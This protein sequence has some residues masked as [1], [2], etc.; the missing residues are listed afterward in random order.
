MTK[1]TMGWKNC[2]V[3]IC[4]GNNKM[5]TSVAS[6]GIMPSKAFLCSWRGSA[7]QQRGAIRIKSKHNVNRHEWI[8][9]PSEQTTLRHKARLAT[10]AANHTTFQR[11]F[12]RVIVGCALLPTRQVGGGSDARARKHSLPLL[13]LLSRSWQITSTA[14]L[15]GGNNN[16][17]A[18]I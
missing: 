4:K 6:L 17:T 8:K 16:P 14:D 13:A 2:A 9:T 7:P 15:R 3:Q 11:V 1:N 5:V 10:A 18:A 12:V